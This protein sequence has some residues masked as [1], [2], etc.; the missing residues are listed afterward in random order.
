MKTT[1]FGRRPSSLTT[2]AL[3]SLAAIAARLASAA[4]LPPPAPEAT[5]VT[6]PPP[7]AAVSVTPPPPPYSLPWQLRPV[8]AVTA[9]RSDTSV[10]FYDTGGVGGDTVATLLTG[11]YQLTPHLAPLVKLG[12]VQND[13]PGTSPSGDSFVNPIV[14][15]TYA[16]R[17][18]AFR[19]AVFAGAA[20]PV[21]QGS[22]DSADK[23]V[24]AANKAAQAAR[25]GM[26]NSM[27]AVNYFTGIIGADAAYVDRNLTVQV[28]ATLFQSLRAHGDDAGAA[29]TDAARTNATTGLHLGYFVIPAL[30]FGAELRYQRYLSTPT[31]LVM[32]AKVPYNDGQKDTTTV[33]IGPRAHFAIGKGM[34]LRPGISYSRALDQPLS[35]SSYNMVQVDLPVVF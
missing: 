23:G 9:V 29:S 17:V 6:S 30:S 21:G 24:V 10:A 12:F 2:C 35:G 26:D 20:I 1:A 13:A 8:A 16:R 14:G 4:E 27:F 32:G 15:V 34:F 5:T 31:S 28:E 7:A 33:A 25:S 19:W 22:G 18:Q 11:S 3:A